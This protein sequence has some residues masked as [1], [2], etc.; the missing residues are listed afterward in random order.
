MPCPGALLGLP[1]WGP[2]RLIPLKARVLVE[3]GVVWIRDLRIIGG[4]LIVCC[5]R[6]GWT[7]IHDLLR[8]F[9][10]EEDVFVGVCFLLA[11][12]VLLLFGGI[13]WTLT[14]AFAPVNRQVG[15]ASACQ[16][17]GRHT[18]RIALGGL[19]EG[20][21]G[22]LQDWQGPMK[23]VVGCGLTQP[24]L[25]AVHRLQGVGL[26]IDQDEEELVFALRQ[27]PCGAAGRRSAADGSSL[28]AS[29]EGDTFFHRPSETQATTAQ[30]RPA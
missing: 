8:V 5:A 9:V 11:A 30:T 1:G 10:D 2:C 4:L 26:L 29:G 15:T 28:P 16:I 21:Q 19:P 14:A 3:R 25:Q 23:P 6:H 18:T 17:T 13:F 12:V 20:A 22:L 27:C 7:Q 24:K